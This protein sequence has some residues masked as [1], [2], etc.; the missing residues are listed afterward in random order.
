MLNSAQSKSDGGVVKTP[1]GELRAFVATIIGGRGWVVDLLLNYELTIGSDGEADIRVDVPDVVPKHAT[2]RWNGEQIVVT[3][4]GAEDGVHVNGDRITGSVHVN[5]GDEIDIGPAT[6]VVN[7]TVAPVNKGRRSLTH[8]EF[9]E[10]LG[11]ELSRAGR[12]GRTTCLVML[13]S[14]SGD[15]SRLAGAA[16]R[17]VWGGGILAPYAPGRR[18]I[19]RAAP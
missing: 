19:P 9:A 3:E 15:G 8:H 16:P 7:V 4:F 10:R 1:V 6:L 11:E 5:P 2:L 12:G 14:K 13:K 17:T 18:E